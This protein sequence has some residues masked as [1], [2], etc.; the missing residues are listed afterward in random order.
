MFLGYNRKKEISFDKK[1]ELKFSGKEPV[2]SF[3]GKEVKIVL[4]GKFY[5]YSSETKKIFSF[6]KNPQN[7]LN[8]L[9]KKYNNSEDFINNI[10]GEY[11]GV[12]IDYKN[13]SLEIFSD[14][15]KQKE[16]YY[17]YNGDIF[18]ASDDP[19][20][21]IEKIGH[22]G[23]CQQSLMCAIL[24][25]VPKGHTL[26]KGI[27]RL[28]YNELIAI[29][30]DKFFLK[31][32][33]DKDTKIKEYSKKD[34][35]EYNQILRDA[36]LTRASSSFNLVFS[37]GGWD[38]TMILS[39][40]KKHLGKDKIIGVT[41]KIIMSD[42]RCF[43]EF[44]VNK[45][46]RI[47]KSMGIKIDIVEI[48]YRKKELYH[49][50]DEIKDELFFRN[51]F[52]LA[53]ANW[54]KVVSYIK[55]KYGEEAVIFNGEGSDSLHNYGFSQY[56]SLAH[57]NNDFKEYSDKMKNYLFSPE[58]FKKVKNGT[59]SDDTIYKIFLNFNQDKEFVDVK[60]I[61][62][63]KKI[64]Y[65]LLSFALS[66][67]RIPFR[68]IDDKIFIQN[69][70]MQKFK[71]WL[72]KE[73]FEKIVEK[74]DENNLYYYFSYLYTLFHLQ[75]P[76]IQIF[77]NGLKNVRFP[78]IDLNL[79]KFLYRMPQ[80]FGRGL[81]FNHTKFPLKELAKKIFSNEQLKIIKSGPHS[82]L[83]EVERINVYD[84]YLLK[85]AVFEY[86][87]D[88]ISYKEV[89]KSFSSD[90]F[91]LDRIKNFI[92]Q[93]KQGHVNNLSAIEARLL[94]VLTLISACHDG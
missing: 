61:D 44:E 69:G 55:D 10:E 73:Y 28:K 36:I 42:G 13:E 62:F 70:A 66:D 40:L 21:I 30:R 38:S 45:V 2:F 82:Y 84:E 7:Q 52:Y 54:A 60:N 47:G 16:L 11:L 4:A 91:N 58:F 77:R 68:K 41:M 26:F 75:S 46:E 23:Y 76:Q 65:Y 39:I 35:S 59:F 79:F 87:K 37:S 51:L 72:N 90:I 34:L 12:K 57:E 92:E 32:F 19:K 15:L 48:D 81:N 14:K 17:F 63:K 8:D 22:T 83:S 33:D 89:E 64:Y 43:N 71:E 9:V 20:K 56:I 78:F 24:F 18:F 5:Y 3:T 74:I 85:G 6:K 67:I 49:K 86:I 31:R 88:K 50:L 29:N 80:S 94:I 25:C 27:Y 1:I 93:F 53:P